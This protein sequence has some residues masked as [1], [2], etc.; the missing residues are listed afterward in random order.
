M[1]NRNEDASC[2]PQVH[3]FATSGQFLFVELYLQLF[4]STSDGQNAAVP[5]MTLAVNAKDGNIRIFSTFS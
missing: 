4:A 3:W 5:T 2:R 1:V